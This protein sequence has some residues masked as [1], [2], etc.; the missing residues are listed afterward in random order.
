[1]NLR[2]INKH[3][4]LEEISEEKKSKGG[5]ILSEK[6]IKTTRQGKV[7]ATDSVLAAVGDKAIFS[8][9]GPQE[10]LWEGKKY[11][12]AKEVDLLVIVE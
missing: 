4:L 12:I 5:I 6:R 1:M 7:L 9:Y 8:A 10:L 3:I 11:Y 2:P